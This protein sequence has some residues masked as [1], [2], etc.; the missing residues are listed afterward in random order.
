[1]A[2]QNLVTVLERTNPSELN[3]LRA[4]YPE[5]AAILSTA[6]RLGGEAVPTSTTDDTTPSADVMLQL[7][8]SGVA[9]MQQRLDHLLAHVLRR[10]TIASRIKLVGAVAAA[11]A[12]VVTG[13]LAYSDHTKPFAEFAT[14]FFSFIGGMVTILADQVIRS[15]SGLMI[16]ST[17]E[18][19][20]ILSMRLDVERMALRLARAV[21]APVTREELSKILDDLDNKSVEMIRYQ[22]S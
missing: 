20:K 14:G 17:E 12:G 9:A 6:R 8:R 18:H 10:M 3:A 5:S 1:L 7:A 16:A 11:A 21:P 2:Y 22:G 15:P 19:A 13:L 4:Q